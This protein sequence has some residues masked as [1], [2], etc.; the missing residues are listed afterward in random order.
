MNENNFWFWLGVIADV[1]QLVSYNILLNDFNNHDLMRF[2]EHPD[3]LLTTIIE[4]NTE[5]IE[6]LKGG[7]NGYTRTD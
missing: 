4:Q 2:L 7:Q 6:L 1:A 5:I 3:N